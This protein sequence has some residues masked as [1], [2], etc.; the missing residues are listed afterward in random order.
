MKHAL[1][2]VQ[3]E[4]GPRADRRD[5]FEVRRAPG[6]LDYAEVVVGSTHRLSDR[7]RKARETIHQR[8]YTPHHPPRIAQCPG[9]ETAPVRRQ[10]QHRNTASQPVGD[11]TGGI[12][13]TRLAENDHIDVVAARQI[14]KH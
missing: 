7:C 12:G 1:D 6:V 5:L 13:C 3:I 4:Y 10:V 8:R 14:L 2:I 9:G 11:Q